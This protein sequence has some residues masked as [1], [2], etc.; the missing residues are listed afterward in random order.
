M[1]THTTGNDIFQLAQRLWPLPRS[2]TGGGTRETLSMLSE[3]VDGLNICEVPSGTQCFDWIVPNEW[4]IRDG[5]IVTPEGTKIA[6]FKSNNLHVVGY[7]SAVDTTLELEEL[8]QHLHSLPENPDAIPYVTSYYNENWGFCLSHNQ[9]RTLRSGRYQVYIDSTLQPGSMTYGELLIPGIS[10]KEILLSTYICHPSMANNELSGPCVTAFICKWLNSRVNNRYSFRVLFIP[11]T[12]GSIYY[13]SKHLD[14]LRNNTIAGMVVSCVGDERMYSYI[15]SRQKNTLADELALHILK[16]RGFAYKAYSFLDRGS[17]ERQ[18][19]SPGVDL[20]VIGF[21][22]SKYGTYP[23]YHTSLDNLSLIT[24]QGLE[25]SYDF[26]QLWIEMIE[27]HCYPKIRTLCEPQ[28]G[29]RGLYPTLSTLESARIV[30]KMLN[31]ITYSDGSRSLLE[32]ADY[33]GAPIW[34]VHE[35]C[36]DL[37]KHELLDMNPI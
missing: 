17:D 1:S 32:I 19:C 18:Y 37:Q 9:R 22:R 20:P 27:A 2:L 3:T 29:K 23:E 4:N 21:C 34:D 11:E 30:Q 12:I 15:S 25:G 6:D 31:V 33:I 14:Q 36:K 26:I 16:H 7:S 13:I 5:W 8:Q 35:I 28:L 24:A 10:N